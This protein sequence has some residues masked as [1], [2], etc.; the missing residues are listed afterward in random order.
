M[1]Q[2][3]RIL[4]K[5]SI[6]ASF[7]CIGKWIEKYPEI[8]KEILKE[9]HEIINHTYSHYDN[10][11]LGSKKSFNQLSYQQ[12]YEEIEKFN[13]VSKNIL[14]YLS[15]GFR[16]PHFGRAHTADIYEILKKL[17]YIY[18]SSTIDVVNAHSKFG[19][20]YKDKKTGI[21]EIPL[22]CSSKFPFYIFDS[23]SSRSGPRPLFP[24][25]E[26]F[27]KEFYKTIDIFKKT[28]SLIVHYFDP[29]D[30]IQNQKLEKMCLY[31]KNQNIQVVSC[32]DLLNTILS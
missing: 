27:L 18:S 1:P 17:N 22:G 13:V 21:I 9:G 10:E 32:K 15:V 20:P 5:Y 26:E 23:W 29:F 28:Q 19:I 11:E 7:A 30:I 25:D 24:N 3:L 2:V 12:R 4:K 14:N 8:H 16:T 6:L 31:L